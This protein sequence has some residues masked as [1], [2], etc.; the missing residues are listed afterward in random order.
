MVWIIQDGKDEAVFSIFMQMGKVFVIF[1]TNDIIVCNIGLGVVVWTFA[2]SCIVCYSVH[3]FLYLLLFLRFEK[4]IYY[5]EY[6]LSVLFFMG[7]RNSW[8]DLFNSCYSLL[9]NEKWI[10]LFIH[11]YVE[12][13]G[14]SWILVNSCYSLNHLLSFIFSVLISQL[15][16]FLSSSMLVICSTYFSISS[17]SFFKKNKTIF[18]HCHVSI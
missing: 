17:S 1:I 4:K 11:L 16:N 10:Y 18:N 7:I 9:L 5:W 12:W 13:I 14:N 6:E 15:Y 8:I 3:L 2:I